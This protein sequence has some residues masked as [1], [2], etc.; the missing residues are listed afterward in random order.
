MTISIQSKI[1]EKKKNTE[2]RNV[3]LRLC[4][5]NLMSSQSEDSVSLL[6]LA[7]LMR[8]LKFASKM[9]VTLTTVP[10]SILP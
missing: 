8:M 3:Q 10:H 5:S 2:D 7:T 1:M 4:Q 9:W 6:G